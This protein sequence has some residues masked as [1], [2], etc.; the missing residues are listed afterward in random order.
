MYHTCPTG[1]NH[2]NA[3]LPIFDQSLP[4]VEVLSAHWFCVKYELEERRIPDRLRSPSN[5]WLIGNNSPAILSET[6]SHNITH[7]I[8]AH[9][10]FVWRRCALSIPDS[11]RFVKPECRLSIAAPWGQKHPYQHPTLQQPWIK[12]PFSFTCPSGAIGRSDQRE[13]WACSGAIR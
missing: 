10:L 3:Y 1:P 13:R 2:A 5:E 7:T 8:N 12:G 11:D 4:L 6:E 9:L